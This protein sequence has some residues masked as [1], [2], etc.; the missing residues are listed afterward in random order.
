MKIFSFSSV[1]QKYFAACFVI[2]L[3]VKYNYLFLQI[4]QIPSITGLILKNLVAI[5]IIYITAIPLIRNKKGRYAV[6]TFLLAFTCY[7]LSN[8]WYSRYFGNYLSLSDILM[9]QGARPLTVLIRQISR[10]YDLLFT[11]DLILILFFAIKD[12]SS[13]YLANVFSRA[14]KTRVAVVASVTALLL[15]TQIY[16]TNSILGNKEPMALFNKSTASFVNVYGIF[17]LY[18]FEYHS[19][20]QPDKSGSRDARS[21]SVGRDSTQTEISQKNPNIVVIQVES[22]DRKIIDYRHNG[23]EITPFLNSLKK[24]SLYFNNFYAQHVNGSFDAEFSFL[25]STYPINRNYGF[26]TSDL[27]G[28]DS[29]AKILKNKGYTTNAFHGNDKRFFHRHRAFP[30]LGFDRFYS[31]RDFSIGRNLLVDKRL[32]FGINDYD[33]FLQSSDYLTKEKAPFFSFFIT[34]TSHT[35]FDFYPLDLSQQKFEDIDN[36]LVRDYFKSMAFV[37]KAIERFFEQLKARGLDEN[38]LFI[39]YSDHEAVI[40]SDEYSSKS[41][42]DLEKEV[43]V[44]ESIPLFIFHPDIEPREINKEGTTSDLAP[45]VLDLLGEKQRPAEFLGSSLLGKKESPVLFIHET[46]QILYDGQLFV[47]LPGGVEKIG[48]LEKKG[49]RDIGIPREKRILETIEFM[50]NITIERRK[51]SE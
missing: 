44:P 13:A 22:L 11:L 24:K 40:D 43:K 48:F 20:F 17:P 23:T 2:G 4:F 35:P 49:D 31:R 28:F 36:L 18:A 15:L 33:F 14:F 21:P 42:F 10:P 1:Y 25:T 3:L 39:I 32:N 50:K 34:V 5:L 51:T 9:G 37:D 8:L 45:T 27:S 38:T 19:L 47:S 26:K 41:K 7:F 6:F 16:V 29:L 30:E 46:P 12:K